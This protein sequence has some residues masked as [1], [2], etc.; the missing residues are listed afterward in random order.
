MR[1]AFRSLPAVLTVL[2][3]TGIW[4]LPFGRSVQP[5][6]AAQEPQTPRPTDPAT[7]R[8]GRGDRGDVQ[9]PPRDTR[10][11][12]TGTG[13]ISGRL[14]SL[15]GTPVRRAQVRLNAP[16][17]RFSRMA[18]TNN[19][20][21][22]EF[23]ELPAGRY[24]LT[25]SKTGYLVLQYGQRRPL[26]PG[27][28]IDLA[29]GQALTSLDFALPRGS[30]ITGRVVDEFGE[31]IP[32]AAVQ[33]LRYQ[34]VSGQ[35]QLVPAGRAAQTDDI[36]QFRVFGLA[37]GEYYVAASVRATGLGQAIAAQIADRVQS[38]DV[39]PAGTVDFGVAAQGGAIGAVSAG[40]GDVR[41]S[42]GVEPAEPVGYAPTYYPGTSSAAEAQRVTVGVAEEVPGISF[43]LSPVRLSRV[44]GMAV[45]SQGAAIGRG[46]VMVRPSRGG[47]VLLRGNASGGA[48]NN[49][50]FT[51]A[52]VPPGDYLLQIRMGGPNR[53]EGEFA[54]VPISV[55]G[56]DIEGLVIS[57]STGSTLAGRV[58]LTGTNGAANTSSMRIN[59]V[60]TDV[61]LTPM[62]PGTMGTRVS[63]TG[64]FEL[65]GLSGLVLFRVSPLPTGWTLKAVRLSGADI[66]DTPYEFKG[67]E[68]LSGLEIELT[69]KVTEIN[70]VV[71][72]SRGEPLQEYAVVV[73]S[74][75]SERWQPPTRF[76]RTGRPD[77][78]GRFQVRGLP[79]GRYLAVA[80]EYLEQ[81]AE[82]DPE[83]LERLKQAATPLS[84]DE[85]ETRQLELKLSL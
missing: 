80:V 78:E 61:G 9:R 28:P 12:P 40:P 8:G 39:T 18:T 67:G 76:V 35:R 3:V 32:D 31:A 41:W 11:Q 2:A 43:S 50:R 4:G 65:R 68:T 29:A 13:R 27:K 60:S 15:D 24:T 16:E 71:T 83:Q 73:F 19:D 48:I 21:F 63:T 5:L 7:G 56:S 1:V 26:E 75:S 57:T 34:Y 23:K 82:S 36:G 6:V 25:A 37:P 33:A 79:P 66:T 59:V 49:G 47:A 38:G 58:I 72:S 22:F 81:G 44:S 42:A 45:N 69:D 84:L 55:G 20:G 10:P 77:Q 46:M 70:G 53:G 51:I 52:G 74:E 17:I 30:V 85:G 14:G 64:T 62:G 54:S